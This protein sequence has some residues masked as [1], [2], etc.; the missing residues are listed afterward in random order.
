MAFKSGRISASKQ[1]DLQPSFLS[2]PSKI[3]GSR[4]LE[5]F[6]TSFLKDSE[7]RV[8]KSRSFA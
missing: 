8:C 4:L 6:L 3:H 1:S 7:A 2:I 5:P